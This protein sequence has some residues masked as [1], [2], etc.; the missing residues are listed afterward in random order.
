[1]VELCLH[2]TLWYSSS[3]MN[4]PSTA[5]LFVL[6][7]PP[8]ISVVLKADLWFL[9][10]VEATFRT[11]FSHVVCVVVAKALTLFFRASLCA[12][13]RRVRSMFLAPSLLGRF[14]NNVSLFRRRWLYRPLR[15]RWSELPPT[16]LSMLMGGIT[17]FVVLYR[18]TSKVR[19]RIICCGRGMGL[20]VRAVAVSST[21][22][23]MG[24]SV[25]ATTIMF[26]SGRNRIWSFFAILS[27]RTDR[28][29]RW[30][31]ARLVR[32]IKVPCQLEFALLA[33]FFVRTPRSTRTDALLQRRI[34]VLRG[35]GGFL[36]SISMGLAFLNV[37]LSV[38]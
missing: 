14:W 37:A 17:T 26:G 25:A 29:V 2:S 6:G 33:V 32:Q 3:F 13:A 31:N 20:V 27:V 12:S 19:G 10:H 16:V 23:T 15:R 8:N 7:F 28:F 35:R 30:S 34:N 1:M 4:S 22:F 24:M 38:D 36:G 11:R 9:T 5:L 18:K 21:W